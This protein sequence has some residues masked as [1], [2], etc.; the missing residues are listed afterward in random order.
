M[1]HA[2]RIT[3]RCLVEDL[4]ASVDDGDDLDALANKNPIVR[5]FIDRRS[6]SPTGQETVEGLTA[7]IVAFSLHSGE[8]RGLTWHHEPGDTVWLLAAA[9]HRSGKRDDAYPYFRQLGADHRLLPT[10]GD[11]ER[12]VA[13][14]NRNFARVL[15]EDVPKIIENMRRRPGQIF[16]GAL[17]ERV[18]IRAVWEDDDPPLLTVA[19]SQRLLPGELPVPAGYQLAIAAAFLPDADPNQLSFAWELAGHPLRSDEIAYCDFRRF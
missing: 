13:S 16:G 15:I 12:L 2:L 7:R 9:F 8:D 3:E 19:I 10:K 14:R 1:P 5:A 17:G 18:P 11:I 4:G 6:Q